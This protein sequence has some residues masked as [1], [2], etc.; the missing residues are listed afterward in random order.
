MSKRHATLNS[1]INPMRRRF[2]PIEIIELYDRRPGPGGTEKEYPLCLVIKHPGSIFVHEGLKAKAGRTDSVSKTKWQPKQSGYP[3]RGTIQEVR[4]NE[5]DGGFNTYST[6]SALPLVS[7][8]V[9]TTIAA[10]TANIET[11]VSPTAKPY[12][13][14][15][16]PMSGGATAET[17][18]PTL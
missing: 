6:S 13:S 11:V 5:Y 8:R 12:L 7:G 10:A 9:R 3:T 17:P 1:R 2:L 15:R 18:L 4:T 14:T 16:N